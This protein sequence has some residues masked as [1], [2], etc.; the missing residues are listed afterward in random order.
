LIIH[1]FSGLK[2]SEKYF[3]VFFKWPLF[4]TFT[5]YFKEFPTIISLL[6][7][8]VK[9]PMDKSIPLFDNLEKF[10]SDNQIKI[11]EHDIILHN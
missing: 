6:L 10:P 8:F 9:D 4:G 7:G 3:Q 2:K 1:H 5:K 11:G